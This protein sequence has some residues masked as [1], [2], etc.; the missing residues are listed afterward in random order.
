MSDTALPVIFTFDTTANRM[1]FTPTPGVSTQLYI[2]LDS[3]DQPNAYYWDGAT[4]QIFNAGSG[5]S[6]TTTGSPATGQLAIFSGAASITG[7][8]GAVTPQG[9]LTLTTGVP[10]LSSTVTAAGT[11]YY[12]PAIGNLVPIYDGTNW[13]FN[14]FTE[15]SQALTD[16]TK[17]P[18]AATT[19]SNYDL[20]VWNDTGT[21]RCTR[22]PLWTSDTA[23]GTGAGTT[24]LEFVDGILMNKNAITNG[25]GADMGVYVGTIRTNGTSTIDMIFGGAGGAGGEGTIVGIW[26]YYNQK[27]I[28]LANFDTTDNWNYTTATWRL[29][30]AGASTELNK[31]KFINGY[32]GNGI[33]AWNNVL[34]RNSSANIVFRAGIGLN[35]TTTPSF[36]C[37]ISIFTTALVST[38][39]G[40]SSS[41]AG[42]APLG[43]NYVAPLEYSNASG[44]TTWIGD[45][46]GTDV[47][48]CFT[49]L[50]VF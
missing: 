50:T 33:S 21:L 43:F 45:N 5:G 24:E 2:W 20:F 35:T 17:S 13:K 16:N 3:D 48:S 10:Y 38:S 14:T 39:I 7:I 15:L 31:I 23:R 4:W 44:T 19:N 22:G 26:N 30:N 28:S 25:P 41:Y 27:L 34:A 49:A 32:L 29:K 6:V 47:L 42:V 8:S 11:I 12:T 18:A 1:A 40:G 9:R 36:G 37:G 46:G